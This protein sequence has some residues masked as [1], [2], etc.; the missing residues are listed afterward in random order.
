[1]MKET[2]E[3]LHRLNKEL[4][5]ESRE[6]D[7]LISNLIQENTALKKTINKWRLQDESNGIS[8]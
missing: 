2:I 5:L 6:R 7:Q 3:R 8:S 1:M 4:M